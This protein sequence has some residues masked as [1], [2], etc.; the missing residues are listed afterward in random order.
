MHRLPLGYDDLDPVQAAGHR[1]LRTFAERIR[2]L[3][4][5]IRE[6]EKLLTAA[7]TAT[8]Q[9]L[10][11]LSGVGHDSTAALLIAAGD[12]PDRLIGEAAFAALCGVNPA[13][14]SSREAQR[15][16]LN[17]GGN[18]QANAALFW[19]ALTRRPPAA[20][21]NVMRWASW[22]IHGFG[23]RSPAGVV[24]LH[25][26]DELSRRPVGMY[27][28]VMPDERGYGEHHARP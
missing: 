6:L 8:A 4:S 10:L 26:L 22:G 3:S 2:H 21:S 20:Q 17:R 5:E 1:T 24:L 16:R 19:I 25:G 23:F 9:R 27:G 12:N 28:D 18:R 14:R 7:V 15:R 11:G 13:E